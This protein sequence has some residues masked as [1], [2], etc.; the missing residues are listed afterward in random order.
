MTTNVPPITFSDSGVTTPAESAI[1]TG[2][3]EDLNAAFS[4]N[5]DA[6]AAT[7][8][9]QIATSFA[10]IIGNIYDT[11]LDFV[12]QV[13]PTYSSG[14]FQDA[15]GRLYLLERNPATATALQV[16]CTGAADVPIL[17]TALLQDASGNIYQCTVAGTIGSGGTV[18]LPFACQIMGPIPVPDSVTIYSAAAGW[19]AVSIAS[20]TLGKAQE[21]RYAFE[22]RRAAAVSKNG[23]GFV[24]AIRG[25]ILAL[26]GVVDAYVVQNN[27]NAAKEIGG[28]T[29][30]ANSIYVAVQGGTDADVAGAIFTKLAP[31]CSMNGDTTVSVEDNNSGYIEPYPSYDITFE[32]PS[33][34]RIVVLVTIVSGTDVPS[35]VATQIQGAIVSA[36]GGGDGGNAVSIGSSVYATR[37]VG[38]VLA[39]GSWAK[40]ISI[41]IGSINDP[42]A[43]F[44]GSI[45]GTTLTVSSVAS[46]AVAVGAFI[47]DEAGSIAAGTKILSGSGTTWT[48]N[49]SQTVAS[50]SM[51]AVVPSDDYVTVNIDQYPTIS[52]DDI[53]V[54]ED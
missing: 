16:I 46:G 7:P 13:D 5:F 12:N 14:R 31:G 48:V 21:S 30:I 41:K 40:V 25:A 4:T 8:Q 28:Y 33:L 17:T 20:G 15:L 42:A 29:L 9:G 18:T 1:Y 22:Q 52:A 6:D 27:T 45:A 3:I 54:V 10:A 24:S 36:F 53:A 50:E 49:N 2:V 26:D 44:T 11:F 47:V 34:L 51:Y 32:R 19:D 38:P 35:D 39:L 43:T 23:V 37:Y